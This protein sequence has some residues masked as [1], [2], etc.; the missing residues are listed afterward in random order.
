MALKSIF[1]YLNSIV[2]ECFLVKI[3]VWDGMGWDRLWVWCRHRSKDCSMAHRFSFPGIPPFGSAGLFQRKISPT[4]E[5][6]A[7]LQYYSIQV[8]RWCC[9]NQQDQKERRWGLPKR[10]WVG[11]KGN[12]GFVRW[13]L[14]LENVDAEPKSCTARRCLIISK[15]TKCKPEEGAASR[16]HAD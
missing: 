15:K 14:S 13:N 5:A 9:P 12:I 2:F 3:T 4:A 6:G 16:L 1:F 11:T 10:P 8:C 7:T